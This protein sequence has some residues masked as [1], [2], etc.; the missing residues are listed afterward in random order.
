MFE[1]TVTDEGPLR[2]VK[3]ELRAFSKEQACALFEAA[4][5]HAFPYE[6]E[7]E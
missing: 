4:L 5:S 2:E 6:I 1:V 3:I 7:G